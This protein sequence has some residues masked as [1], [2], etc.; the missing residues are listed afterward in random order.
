[1]IALLRNIVTDEPRAIHRTALTPEGQKAP[2]SFPRL[3]LG[4]KA[5]AAVKLSAN[6]DVSTRLA[7]GEGIETTIAGMMLQF[8]PAWALGDA[9][10]LGAFP[11]LPGIESLTIFVDHDLSRGRAG[12]RRARQ[13]S[14]RW[15]SA[16]CEVFR[17]I[18]TRPGAD[19]NDVVRERLAG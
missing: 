17:V 13:C 2:I 12:Q 14:D 18:P 15:T 9:G 3:T 8:A 16:G 1:M 7:I 6:E 19:L 10:E 11:V 5:G 4:S